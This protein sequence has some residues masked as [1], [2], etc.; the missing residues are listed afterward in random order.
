MLAALDHCI[1]DYDLVEYIKGG[2]GPS[3]R[4]FTRALDVTQAEIS[5]DT[6]YGLLLI[7]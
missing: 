6:L 1:S 5:F 4:P 3:Y 7:E 2:L